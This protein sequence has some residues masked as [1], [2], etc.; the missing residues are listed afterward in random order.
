MKPI[1]DLIGQ[2]QKIKWELMHV[3][4][5]DKLRREAPPPKPRDPMLDLSW[6]DLSHPGTRSQLF[7]LPYVPDAIPNEERFQLLIKDLVP[8]IRG[9]KVCLQQ[10][11]QLDCPRSSVMEETCL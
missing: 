11:Y 5:E 10:D 9:A 2:L 6:F 8:L 7:H 1:H 3:E 4:S